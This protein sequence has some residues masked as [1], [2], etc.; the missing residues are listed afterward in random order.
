MWKD[1]TSDIKQVLVIFVT[2]PITQYV[3]S[4]ICSRRSRIY[5]RWG[6]QLQ[7]WMLKAIIWPIFPKTAWNWKNLDPQWVGV[8]GAPS[9]DA[10]MVCAWS[11]TNSLTV[12][13]QLSMEAKF[14]CPKMCQHGRTRTF[15]HFTVKFNVFRPPYQKKITST[16]MK[17]PFMVT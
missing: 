17:L 1:K 15:L 8:P 13:R 3:L 9:L 7:M 12:I 10:P 11:L 2:H 5:A 6:H 16:S 4:I 14:S